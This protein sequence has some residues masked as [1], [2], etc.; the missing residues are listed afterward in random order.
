MTDLRQLMHETVEHDHARPG[1]AARART[2]GTSMRRRRR[3]ATTGAVLTALAVVG[4]GAALTG[5]LGGPDERAAEVASVPPANALETLRATVVAVVPDAT[6]SDVTS[7]NRYDDPNGPYAKAALTITPPGSSVGSVMELDYFPQ[8]VPDPLDTMCDG[9]EDMSCQVRTLP[10]G[11]YL[12][13][14]E[15]EAGRGDAKGWV[16]DAVRYVDGYAIGVDIATPVDGEDQF[17]G[18]EPVLTKAQLAA[19]MSQPAWENV[20]PL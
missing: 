14:Y 2:R 10:D 15:L 3:L 20:L 19:V 12:L 4:A 11:S 5:V 17:I 7:F 16:Y 8:E 9:G 13:T 1:L 18:T 6:I